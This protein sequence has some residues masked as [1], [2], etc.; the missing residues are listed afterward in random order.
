[1][2]TSC[3]TTSKCTALYCLASIYIGMHYCAKRGTTVINAAGTALAN[4]LETFTGW[5]RYHGYPSHNARQLRVPETL[6]LPK[7]HCFVRSTAVV[8]DHPSAVVLTP[9]KLSDTWHGTCNTHTHAKMFLRLRGSCCTCCI[10]V[11]IMLAIPVVLV[12]SLTYLEEVLPHASGSLRCS[13][14][15]LVDGNPIKGVL[16]PWVPLPKG[17]LCDGVAQVK[18]LV[19]KGNQVMHMHVA[20][21]IG[22]A[23]RKVDIPCY[24][25]TAHHNQA[26]GVHSQQLG[27]LSLPTR[28][29]MLSIY[30]GMSTAKQHLQ[31]KPSNI[32]HD[33]PKVCVGLII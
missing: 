5:E 6:S 23:R 3:N 19:R 17:Q 8:C 10:H 30:P 13:R 2:H 12:Q 33:K 32:A 16:L 11:C 31:S 28:S 14:S 15:G 7:V 18:V 22:F 4:V 20:L 26:T 29:I 25:R 1:M 27:T 24:L 9:Q 21:L